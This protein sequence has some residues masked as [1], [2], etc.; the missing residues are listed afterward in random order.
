MSSKLHFVVAGFGNSKLA[1]S[2]HSLRLCS[3][4]AVSLPPKKTIQA[5]EISAS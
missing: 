2:R 3:S 4:H 1:E 5:A